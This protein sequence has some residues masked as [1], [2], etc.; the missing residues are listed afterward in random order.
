MIDIIS[1]DVIRATCIIK[2]LYRRA[3]VSMGSVLE[4]CKMGYLVRN[5]LPSRLQV[6]DTRALETAM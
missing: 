5:I 3:V 4:L 1:R 2:N 6:K